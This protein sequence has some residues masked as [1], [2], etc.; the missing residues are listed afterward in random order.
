VKLKLE[1]TSEC[2]LS[3]KCK[4][5]VPLGREEGVKV[6]WCPGYSHLLL[7]GKKQHCQSPKHERGEQNKDQPAAQ[8]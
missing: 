2:F 7:L 6:C 3:K 8:Q 5:N 4:R 1:M